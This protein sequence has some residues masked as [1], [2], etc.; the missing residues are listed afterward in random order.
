MSA[1]TQTPIRKSLQTEAQYLK[2]VGPRVAGILAKVGLHTVGDVL[3]HLPRRYEDRR[4]IPPIHEARP[5]DWVTIRGQVMGVQANSAKRG[6]VIVKVPVTDGRSTIVLTWF[7]QP[8]QKKKFETFRGEVMAYG[9]VKEGAWDL[10]MNSPECE[11][12]GEDDDP[13]DFARIVAVYPLSE[14][15]PQGLVRRAVDSALDHY[16]ECVEDPVPEPVLRKYGLRPL[17]WSL[18]QIHQPID[19]KARL[20]ARKRLVF[21][22]FFI[23]QLTLALSRAQTHHEIGLAFP[24]GEERDQLWKDIHKIFPFEMTPAQS[25]VVEEIWKDMEAPHPM[26]RLL[27]GDVGSGKTAVAACAM[28][29][30]VRAGYQTAIMA[31]TEILAEQHYASLSQLFEPIGIETVLLVGKHSAATK[32]KAYEHTESGKA[33]IAIGTQALIQEGVKFKKLGLI[34]VDEQHRFGVVQRAALREKGM[35]NPDVLVMTATPIPRTL[36]MAVFGDLDLSVIDELPPGRKPVKTH[37]KQLS[38][39]QSVYEGVRKLIA[40]GRQAYFVCPMVSESEKALA[41]AAE[42]LYARLTVQVF[43]DLRVGLLHGQMKAKDKEKVMEQFRAHDLDILVSTTVIEV[44]V[45]VPNASVMVIE[46]ANRFGLS[47]LHQLRGR[48]GRASIQSFCILVSDAKTDEAR[49]RLETIASTNDGFKIA[50]EDLIQRGP[51]ELI[52]TKQSGNLGIKIGDLVQDGK[53]MEVARQA[54]I[55]LVKLDQTLSRPEHSGLLARASR[56]RASGASIAVS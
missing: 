7:N 31:P 17:K 14:G 16:L 46:D 4:N 20:E 43:P 37:W 19:E 28:L 24:I 42:E 10:E 30:A 12:I 39:R 48:V 8:W 27:Q 50:E 2:G 9:Q 21:D 55:D 36:T 29:A 6:I 1:P 38:D 15:V 22:E 33:S 35:G 18:S 45:D 32:K 56:K 49:A 3:Y 25:R 34:V 5:G 26:N 41:L 52:G 13:A 54:A 23:V 53:M 40:E 11:L 51:G 44:G 47:Q